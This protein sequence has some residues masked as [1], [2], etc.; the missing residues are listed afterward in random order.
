M[1]LRG[2]FWENQA[3]LRNF[4]TWHILNVQK[5]NTIWKYNIFVYKFKKWKLSHVAHIVTMVIQSFDL[6]AR[7][8]KK[9]SNKKMVKYDIL[10]LHVYKM[11]YLCHL[12]LCINENNSLIL[13]SQKNIFWPQVSWRSGWGHFKVT[14]NF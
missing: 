4:G 11:Y 14:C 12:N 1:C 2:I 9:K 5:L 7:F 10:V 13:L 3:I 8:R 6:Y